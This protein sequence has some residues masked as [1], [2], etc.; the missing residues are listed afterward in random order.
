[1]RLTGAG[2]KKWKDHGMESDS[3]LVLIIEKDDVGQRQPSNW[4]HQVRRVIGRWTS[5]RDRHS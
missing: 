2:R 4:T 5:S 1:V 3:G